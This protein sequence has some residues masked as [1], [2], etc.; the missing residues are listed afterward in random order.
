M[1][2]IEQGETDSVEKGGSLSDNLWDS[3]TD[4]A[5]SELSAQDEPERLRHE[6]DFWRAMFDQLVESFPEGVLVTTADGTLTH[7]ND[8]LAAHLN[9]PSADA[10]G[11]NAYDVIGTENKDET[12]AETVARTGDVIQEDGVRE[13]PTTDAIFQTYGVPLRGPDGTVVGAFEVA[14]DVSEHI[15]QQRQ[16]ETLQE[17]VSGTVRGELS[18][19]SDAIDDIVALTDS[20]ETFAKQQTDRVDQVS[21]E[22]AGQSAV[23][24]EI[25]SSTQQVSQSAK[26]AQS[27]AQEGEETAEAAIDQME[28]VRE[29][30]SAVGDTI[31]DLTNQADEM[32]EIIDL[33]NDIADQTNMLALNASIEAARA[34]EAGEGFSVVA[35]EVKSLAEESQTQASEIEEMVTEMVDATERT[36]AELRETTDEIADAIDAVERTVN[37]LNEIHE[38]VNE[39]ATAAEEVADAT[40]DHAASTEEVA[41]TIDEAADELATLKQ[42]LSDLSAVA[43]EQ[44]EQV[45]EI[46]G[47]VDELVS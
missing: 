44:Y 34:G 41:A 9:I 21:E 42:Q 43:D 1:S 26:R 28:G 8:E 6:R 3:Y 19:L 4:A 18:D 32:S 40:D 11:E 36:A 39:T 25:A 47:S 2:S 24:E 20:I 38:Q 16:L 15:E 37:S 35:D 45:E 10:L 22:V 7:W 27:R 30:A 33:I 5:D 23:I 17:Q 46:E 13:V 29:S 14:P 31:D 12:L